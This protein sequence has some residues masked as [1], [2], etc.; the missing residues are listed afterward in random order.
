MPDMPLI[1]RSGLEDISATDRHE[2]VGVTI[3]ERRGVALASVCARRNQVGEL[4]A[5]VRD[6][7]GLVLSDRRECL[8]ADPISLLWA[9]AGQ[10]LAMAAAEDG[11][12]LERRLRAALG[13]LAS[14]SDQSDARA[15]IRVA[16]ARAR[17][18]LAKGVPID[19]HA[20]AFQTGE[21]A[22]TTVAHIGVHIWQVDE[23]PTYEF[24]APRSFAMSFWEWL[25]A[26]A[27]EFR[28]G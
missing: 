9:G 10:W 8:L 27:A 6:S 14:V 21:A 3:A 13:D 11:A 18:V 23:T 20:R 4:I 15:I 26:S 16:G 28:L 19:L 7:F 17:D 12:A 22:M 25:T 1:P 24:I 2:Y 5:R